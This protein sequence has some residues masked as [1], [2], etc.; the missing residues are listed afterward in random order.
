MANRSGFW[1]SESR[2]CALG[3]DFG[4]LSVNWE[5][6][7]VKFLELWKLFLV[8]ESQIGPLEVYFLSIEGDL[9]S[10]SRILGLK[11]SKLVV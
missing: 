4:L 5:L 3:V 9:G 7:L 2:F 6:F 10:D 11:K 1:A 8:S